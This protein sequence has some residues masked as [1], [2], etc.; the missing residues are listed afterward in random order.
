M[1]SLQSKNEQKT[2]RISLVA[3]NESNASTHR[4]KDS[5]TESVC[6]SD[7]RSSS[8][9]SVVV[10]T[11]TT[12]SVVN[13]LKQLTSGCS[14]TDAESPVTSASC[15]MSQDSVALENDSSALLSQCKSL[16]VV[17][18]KMHSDN[19]TPSPTVVAKAASRRRKGGLTRRHFGSVTKLEVSADG[20]QMKGESS[21]DADMSSSMCAD[22]ALLAADK[23]AVEP[24]S[25]G[26]EY[27]F[28]DDVL[29]DSLL[30]QRIP[31][32]ERKTSSRKTRNSVPAADHIAMSPAAA[33]DSSS[34]GA[35]S[36]VDSS[37]ASGNTL[38]RSVTPNAI[39]KVLSK[40]ETERGRSRRR[41]QNLQEDEDTRSLSPFTQNSSSLAPVVEASL[42]G[43][44]LKL[45]I[46]K[47]TSRSTEASTCDA[48]VVVPP[49]SSVELIDNKTELEVNE[50]AVPYN[51]SP[52]AVEVTAEQ[53]S[54]RRRQLKVEGVRSRFLT[55]HKPSGVLPSA[56]H[57]KCR[58]V[59]V[60]RR[61]WMSVG[62][63]EPDD[64]DSDA[65]TPVINSPVASSI[66][67]MAQ[68]PTRDR[69]LLVNE[70][71]KQRRRGRPAKAK[72]N[73]ADANSTVVS[74]K[75]TKQ[76]VKTDA[77]LLKISFAKPEPLCEVPWLDCE[78]DNSEMQPYHALVDSSLRTIATD[79][80]ECRSRALT[81]ADFT[82]NI[83][84]VISDALS[85]CGIEFPRD[86]V[87]TP[88]STFFVPSELERLMED[89]VLDDWRRQPR[90]HT[91]SMVEAH[92]THNQRTVGMGRTFTYSNSVLPP[93]LSSRNNSEM[94]LLLS[95]PSLRLHT[96]TSSPVNAND[97]SD[98]DC[99]VVGYEYPARCYPDSVE[100]PLLL[101]QQFLDE[102]YLLPSACQTDPQLYSCVD[103][104][105]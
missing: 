76:R 102:D 5:R 64:A 101:D 3:V 39:Q 29:S 7:K 53:V 67:E 80:E 18:E 52:P 91:P 94:D 98:Y 59:K 20:K 78:T 83:D 37:V 12:A 86:T 4:V 89:L 49:L 21:M 74:P 81:P 73:L 104:V 72:T 11:T 6:N 23:A 1:T 44:K 15:V 27:R 58:L 45:R 90:I 95:Q 85:D 19:G 79:I 100:L 61:H 2:L 36:S 28:T 47:F 17:L 25:V 51:E 33:S 70:R 84:L 97:S 57:V 68:H 56:D 35:T 77:S 96:C 13:N 41:K 82:A 38:I 26:D 60:G 65:E 9:P 32:P 48:K 103:L 63:D 55:L 40:S 43:H 34:R 46:T 10:Y 62:G 71:K 92:E 93:V 16:S 99:T 87:L 75:H 54:R 8:S 30:P 105:L 24:L 69:L 14:L 66:D 31:R 42:D 50:V 88:R 22:V